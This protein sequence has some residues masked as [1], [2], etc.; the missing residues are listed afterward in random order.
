MGV[1]SVANNNGITFLTGSNDNTVK[2]CDTKNG[3]YLKISFGYSAFFTSVARLDMTTFISRSW[4][5]TIKLWNMETGKCLRNYNG[6]K[7]YV[8]AVIRGM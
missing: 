2:P 7:K 5:C 1:S 6:N 4:D 3:K 8:T